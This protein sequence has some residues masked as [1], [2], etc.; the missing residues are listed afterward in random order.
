MIFT[1]K[2]KTQINILH[3]PTAEEPFVLIYK[4]RGLASAPLTEND[5]IN[6]L[7][8][9]AE[10]FPQIK[11]VQGKKEIEYGLVHRIDTD[12]DGLLL[13][14]SDQNFY[15]F[16][17]EEQQ[18]DRFIKTYHAYCDFFE[19]ISEHKEGFPVCENSTKIKNL[20]DG[21]SI[22]FIQKSA[23]RPFG[24]GRREVR[25]VVPQSNTAALKKSGDKIYTTEISVTKLVGQRNDECLANNVISSTNF[26]YTALCKITNGYRHQVRC[27]LAWCGLPVTGDRKYNP[28]Y[29]ITSTNLNDENIL[30]NKKTLSKDLPSK[31]FSFTASGLQF[32]NYLCP[33]G[34]LNS[35][36]IA[37]TST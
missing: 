31:E 17:I 7:S 23:F 9:T 25:P 6:A 16:I 15:D 33:E 19:N 28:S 30:E 37:L 14:A 1:V 20:K 22:T 10:Q 2:D 4:P 35:Y 13:I 18:N 3:K 21:E 36:E 8:M 32:R 12:T 26:S 27:H 11:S 29:Q 5:K 34:D 24:P